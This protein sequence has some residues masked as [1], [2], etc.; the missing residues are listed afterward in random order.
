MFTYKF[1]EKNDE[2]VLQSKVEKSGLTTEFTIQDVLDHLEHTKKTLLETVTQM[3]IEDIQNK[4]IEE[5]QPV[6]K[7]IKEDQ[8]QMVIQYLA[9]KMQRPESLSLKETCEKTIKSYEDQVELMKEQLGIDIQ[10]PIE[11]PYMPIHEKIKLKEEGTEST[12]SD[13][14]PK[15]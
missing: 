9:R 15:K 2:D 10:L 5:M 7:D 13:S 6:V 11:S 3:D 4:A 12:E 8:Y 14:E 1:V